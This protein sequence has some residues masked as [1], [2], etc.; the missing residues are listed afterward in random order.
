MTIN[1]NCNVQKL[2]AN[3]LKKKYKKVHSYILNFINIHRV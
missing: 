3:I 2:I 1:I